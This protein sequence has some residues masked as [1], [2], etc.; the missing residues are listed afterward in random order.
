[1]FVGS[2][3]ERRSAAAPSGLADFGGASAAICQPFVPSNASVKTTLP[4]IETSILILPRRS[5]R[6]SPSAE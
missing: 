6:H 2:W 4:P 3:A 1:M 5:T